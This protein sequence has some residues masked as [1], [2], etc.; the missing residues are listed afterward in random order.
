MA[1]TNRSVIN[2]KPKPFIST[3]RTSITYTGSTA[4][5]QIKLPLMVD[6][7]YNFTIQWGDSTSDTITTW[8]QAETTHTYATPG[9]YIVTITGFIKGWD[10]GGGATTI[11]TTGDMR[12]LLTITQFGCLQFIT[13]LVSTPVSIWGAFY[14]CINLTLNSVTDTPNFK[15]TISTQGLFRSCSAI[16]TINNSDK[17]DVSKIQIFRNMFRDMALFNSNVGSWNTSAGTDFGALFS[18]NAIS[19]TS[20]FNNGG[21]DSIRYW[22]TSN[23]TNMNGMFNGQSKFDQ[24]IGDWDVSNV[25][26]M[27]FILQGP[28]TSPHGVF[29]NGGSD[30]IKNWNTSKVTN[31]NIMLASQPNF[32]QPIGNWNTSNVTNMSFVFYSYT[33][34]VTTFNQDISNWDT[35]KVTNMD[36]MFRR[37][38]AFNGNIGNWNVSLVGNF[39]NFMANR[40]FNEYS[41]SSYDA[42]LIGWASRSVKPNISINFGTIKYTAAA[43]ASRAILTSAPNNWTIADGGLI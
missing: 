21:S 6:G 3:W 31:M 43:S 23:V 27:G 11:P 12:K 2:T 13:K 40:T 8:N 34:G 37:V 38:S 35:S 15:G 5:N 22:N 29:N 42:L 32:N 1:R 17:W 26:D 39:N 41:T 7:L 33:T 25:T 20:S 9:D 28:S 16:T 19:T 14:G 10:W 18:I 24:P 4:N 36:Q 30:S